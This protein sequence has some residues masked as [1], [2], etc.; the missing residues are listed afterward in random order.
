MNIREV[1]AKSLLR[2]QKKVDSWFLSSYGMNLYRGCTHNCI[3]CDGRAETYNVDGEFGKDISVKVNVIDLLSRELNP[4]RKRK[5]INKGFF[6]VG[7]GVCDS[8]Q[9]VETKYE[10]TRSALKLLLKYNHPVHMLTKSI[11]ILRDMALLKQI[12][13]RSCVIVSMSFSSVDDKL[14][15]II[16]P[17]VPPPSKRLET[18]AKFKEEGITCGM[19]LMPII[20]FITDSPTQLENTVRAAKEYGLDYVVFGGMTLKEGRQKEYFINILKRH[21]PQFLIEY[22]M[23]YPPDKWGNAIP[24]YYE[25]L[26]QLFFSIAL[27]HKIP[28]R[29]PVLGLRNFFDENN[30]IIIILEHLDYISKLKNQS[31]PFGY[32]AYSVS[33]LDK[34]LSSMRANLCSI[35][36]VGK[37]TEKIILEILETGSCERYKELFLIR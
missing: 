5:P 1:Q 24:A 27:K 36:G 28:L 25:Q 12:N 19:F 11:L 6:V 30:F 23:L 17:G 32:A 21:Y 14:S 10:L 2:K 8:Y 37:F 4:A 9:P 26:N 15:S 16:E 22:D 31:S 29:I 13:E 34:P 20:P 18:L 7:G 35:K 3:Y 33:Q